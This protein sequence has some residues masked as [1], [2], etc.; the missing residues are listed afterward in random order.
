ESVIGRQAFMRKLMLENR[1]VRDKEQLLPVMATLKKIA[2]QNQLSVIEDEATLDLAR[3]WRRMTNMK[4]AAGIESSKPALLA[5]A[6]AA[7]STDAA[8]RNTANE[9]GSALLKQLLQAHI[10]QQQWLPAVRLWRAFP[11]LRPK[12]GTARE[13]RFGIAHAMRMIM[14]LDPAEAMLAELYQADKNSVQGQRIMTERIKLWHDRNDKDAVEKSMRWLN[15]HEFTIYRPEILATIAR[16]QLHNNQAEAARQT[17]S[18]VKASDLAVESRASYWRTHGEIS[19]SL[20]QWHSA[21]KAWQHYRNIA[22]ADPVKGLRHQADALFM[23]EQYAAAGKLY[24]SLPESLHDTAWQYRVAM[25]QLH[26][27]QTAAATEKM[28]ALADSGTSDTYT[29]LAKLALADQLAGRLLK[30][31]P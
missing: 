12:P 26:T 5:Y 25:C 31:R 11:Q 7:T 10:D 23:A 21:A 29:S 20:A 13:L 3:L 15:A 28:Q 6:H 30:E 17:L 8:I 27:G 2:D 24:R 19:E 22:G 18:G 1:R 9:E 14:M 4:H 16:I